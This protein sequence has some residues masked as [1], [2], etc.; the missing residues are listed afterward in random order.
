MQMRYFF[1]AFRKSASDLRQNEAGG[2]TTLALFGIVTCA[3]IGGVAIDVSNLYRQ[4]EHLTLAADAAA[5]AGIVAVAADKP[6]ADIQKAIADAIEA[7]APASM[8]GKVANV[9]DI[10]VVNYNPTTKTL[11]A[12]TPNA[13]KVTLRRDKSVENPVKTSLL[14]LVGVDEFELDVSSVAF[15]GQPGNCESSDGIYGKGQV[16]ITS[17]NWIGPSYCVHSQT[18]VWL[19]QQNTFAKGSGVSMPSLAACKGKCV[20]SANPGIEAAKFTM[21]L[22]LPNVGD[23][24]AKT[25]ADLT[26][27]SSPTKTQVFSNKTRAA[28]LSGLTTAKITKNKAQENALQLGSVVKLTANQYNDLMAATNGLLP[29][30]LVYDVDCKNNGNGPATSIS[31][32]GSKNRTNTS[33][34]ASTIE[35]VRGVVIIADCSFDVGPFARVDNSVLISTRVTSSSA[36]NAEEG[37]VVGDPAR[38]CDLNRKVYVLT[39]SGFSVN[40][41]FTASNVAM[42]ANGDINVAANSSSSNTTHKGTSFHAEGSIQIPANHTFESCGK[43]ASRLLPNLRTFKYVM[44]S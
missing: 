30:G 25:V 27:A 43:D 16:T 17:G 41:N 39:Q 18:A 29:S 15:Y 44:P 13:V 22:D 8:F 14:R 12:G 31:I 4:K 38:N 10:Q 3:M 2:V 33:L 9:T 20:D 32:G 11:G 42:I 40:S 28:N 26:G 7:N 35:T 23:F 1:T 6:A 5:F 36:I 21:N 24:I 37:A 19:P 34:S